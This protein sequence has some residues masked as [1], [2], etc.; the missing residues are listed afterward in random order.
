MYLFVFILDVVVDVASV[1][2]FLSQTKAIAAQDRKFISRMHNEY[3][4]GKFIGVL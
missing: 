1:V 3:S 4:L 2:V